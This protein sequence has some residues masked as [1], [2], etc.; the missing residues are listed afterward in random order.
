[1]AATSV[2]QNGRYH[3]IAATCFVQPSMTMT[4]VVY[5]SMILLCHDDMYHMCEVSYEYDST[6]EYSCQQQ[7]TAANSRRSNMTDCNLYE[8]VRSIPYGKRR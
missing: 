4:A 7:Q 5:S 6:H 8:Y 3:I 2:R 1:M